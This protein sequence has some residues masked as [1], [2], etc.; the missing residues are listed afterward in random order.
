VPLFDSEGRGA[1]DSLGRYFGR[2]NLIE[3]VRNNFA[4]HYSPE[5]IRA[6]YQTLVNGDP[7]DVYLSRTNANTLYAFAESIAGRSLMESI[8]P[9]DHARAFDS[10][11]VETSRAVG[12]FNTLVGACMATCLRRHIGGDLYALGAHVINVEGAP[13][14]RGV[15]LPYFV[16]LAENGDP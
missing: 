14:W 1:I 8:D 4:F 10:L 5:Q 16:E 13:D 12:W 3:T 6:G 7:L 15:E 11:I 9:A 2:A